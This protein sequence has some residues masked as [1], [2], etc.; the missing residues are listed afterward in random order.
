MPEQD[1]ISKA[2]EIATDMY[3]VTGDELST[4]SRNWRVW[5]ARAC[6]FYAIRS[7]AS[8]IMFRKIKEY[9]PRHHSTMIY[10]IN[11]INDLKKYSVMKRTDNEVLFLQ[12]VDKCTTLLKEFIESRI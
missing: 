9:I 12:N 4:N 11:K 1:I 8:Q 10:A 7:V 3:G 2:I 5:Q 6:V